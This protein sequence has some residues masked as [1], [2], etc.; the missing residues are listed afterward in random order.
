MEM[1]ARRELSGRYSLIDTVT[2]DL[3]GSYETEEAALR[4]VAEY[5]RTYGA[6][7]EAVRTLALIRH[8][9]PAAVGGV[10]AGAGLVALATG[11]AGGG[12]VGGGSVGS[13]PHP[14][15]PTHVG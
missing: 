2:T 7:S 8:D 14:A 11:R 5:A 4:D 13:P 3:V 15:R 1:Q 6:D 9:V 12:L 10:A